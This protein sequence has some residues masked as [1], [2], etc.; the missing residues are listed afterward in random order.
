MATLKTKVDTKGNQT[1][2]KG[3]TAYD[4]AKTAVGVLKDRVGKNDGSF[5]KASKIASDAQKDYK[6][7]VD[8][9]YRKAGTAGGNV[10]KS[11]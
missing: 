4:R 11:K 5:R 8:Q 7:T 3:K 1:Y 2:I 9:K 6:K 10:K